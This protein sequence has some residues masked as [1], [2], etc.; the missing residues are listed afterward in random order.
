MGVSVPCMLA[1]R[2]S[3]R[4][5]NNHGRYA[6][7]EP[8]KV[9]NMINQCGEHDHVNFHYMYSQQLCGRYMP[10]YIFRQTMRSHICGI[11]ACSM[12]PY[13]CICIIF[14]D[15]GCWLLTAPW[16]CCNCKWYEYAFHFVIHAPTHDCLFIHG[17]RHGGRRIDEAKLK[18]NPA[19][20]CLS[21]LQYNDEVLDWIWGDSWLFFISPFS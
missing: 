21:F 7:L 8:D 12:S 20:Q 5:G 1:V 15:P 10:L 14:S 19:F 3:H 9:K 17:K 6:C 11:R 13:I 2:T 4:Q 18:W 16:S